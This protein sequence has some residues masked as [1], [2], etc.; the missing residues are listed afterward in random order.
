MSYGPA[1]LMKFWLLLSVRLPVRLS[2]GG[3]LRGGASDPGQQA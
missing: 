3:F 1:R 2:V